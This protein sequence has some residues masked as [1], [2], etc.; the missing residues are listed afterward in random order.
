[1]SSAP[2]IASQGLFQQLLLDCDDLIFYER[3]TKGQLTYVSPSV[4]TVLGVPP[5]KLLGQIPTEAVGVVGKLSPREF[6]TANRQ[7]IFSVALQHAKGHTVEFEVVENRS[8]MDGTVRI[9]GFARDITQRRDF[10]RQLRLSDEILRNVETM[11][12]V[13]DSAGLVVYGSPSIDRILGFAQAEIKGFGWWT[14]TRTDSDAQRRAA[15]RAAEI[16]SGVRKPRPEPFEHEVIDRQGRKHWILWQESRSSNNLAIFCGQDITSRRE[17]EN[18]LKWRTEELQRSEQQLRAIFDCALEG[19]FLLGDDGQIFDVNPSGAAILRRGREQIIGYCI[20]EF[21]RDGSAADAILSDLRRKGWTRA[22]L[23]IIH[24][25][26]DIAYTECTL[27]AN[28]LPSLHLLVMRDQT[29]RRELEEQLRQAQ[30]MEAIGRLAGGVAHDINNMLTVIHGYSELM[31]RSLPTED[32]L[33]RH[34]G[35]ILGAVDRCSMITQQLLAFSRRQ[36]LQPQNVN[37]NKVVAEMSRLLQKLLGED[38]QLCMRLSPGLGDVMADPGQ[39]GQILL[40]LAVNARDAMPT[41]GWITIETRNA[42]LQERLAISA[43]TLEAGEYVTLSISDNGCGMRPEIKSHI[44]E[45]FFTTKELG[46]GTGL[47][48]STVYGIVRQNHGAVLVQSE[49]GKGSTFTVYLPR[50]GTQNALITSGS[51]S[52]QEP[53]TCES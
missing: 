34:A 11:I 19:M 13:A 2:Q 43:F 5:E 48:L 37:L 47:G 42:T 24:G 22:E 27:K 10:E 30:K 31:L 14:K 20:R 23:Q 6:A 18:E 1:M 49:P 8:T 51:I 21:A 50:A 32:P 15:T 36:I 7:R 26:G 41:G 25:N 38:V 28:I 12:L 35:C 17:A 33:R 45:P 4:R 53:P 3:T 29:L 39:L 44:F 9:F 46:K 52:L 40:N 16:A